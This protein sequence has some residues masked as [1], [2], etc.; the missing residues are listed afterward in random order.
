VYFLLFFK[1]RVEA[2]QGISKVFSINMGI[3]LRGGDALMA[4]HFLN[5]PKVG[6]ALY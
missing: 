5:S 4:Q 1:G 2:I 6:P 3:D